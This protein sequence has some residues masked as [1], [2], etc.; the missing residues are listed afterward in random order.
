MSLPGYVARALHRFQHPDPTRAQHAPHDWIPPSYG[1]K[2]Q[3]TIPVD[4]TDSLEPPVITRIQEIVGTL[5]YY[6]RAVDSSMLVALG[7]LAAASNTKAQAQTIT[8]LLNYCATK[9]EATVHYSASDMSLKIHSDTSYLSEPKAR[10]R[11]GGYFYLSSYLD[12][13]CLTGSIPPDV[14]NL[15]QLNTYELQNNGFTEKLLLRNNNFVGDMPDEI[16]NMLVTDNMI[17]GHITVLTADCD[18]VDCICCTTCYPEQSNVL[19]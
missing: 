14:G 13:N 11:A 2:Q 18:E 12:N 4:T 17:R 19:N 6:G 3:L 5:L 9:T 10:S 7:S 16:C 8:H 15:T 1:S